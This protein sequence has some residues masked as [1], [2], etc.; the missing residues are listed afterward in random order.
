MREMRK[1]WLDG[2]G[3]KEGKRKRRK[4]EGEGGE[5]EREREKMKENS[6]SLRRAEVLPEQAGEAGG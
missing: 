1:N 4:K 5:R 2:G 3:E 6:F